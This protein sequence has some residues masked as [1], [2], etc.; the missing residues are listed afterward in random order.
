MKL[1]GR[2]EFMFQEAT[3]SAKNYDNVSDAATKS[4]YVWLFLQLL[5]FGIAPTRFRVSGTASSRC[6]M[7]DSHIDVLIRGQ[8]VKAAGRGTGRRHFPPTTYTAG[9]LPAR[10]RRGWI[11]FMTP[12]RM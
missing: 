4:L 1:F 8:T 7:C 3:K 2:R 5:G 6:A 9:S 11:R 10:A 12:N